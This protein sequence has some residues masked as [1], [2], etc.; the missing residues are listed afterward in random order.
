MDLKVIY[1][2]NPPVNALSSKLRLYLL[3]EIKEAENNDKVYGIVLRGRNSLF[4]GGADIKEFNDGSYSNYP[5]LIDLVHLLAR[6]PKPTIAWTEGATLG[7]GVELAIGCQFR[8]AMETSK[9]A[10]PEINL[11]IIPAAGA[12]QLL[13]RL[14]GLDCAMTSCTSGKFYSASEA[15]AAGAI[16]AIVTSYEDAMKVCHN[17]CSSGRKKTCLLDLPVKG[18][19]NK[20]E[21]FSKQM[22]RVKQKW[23]GAE[24]PL[25]CLDVIKSSASCSFQQGLDLERE[26]FLQ[27]CVS[28]QSK[29]LRYIFFAERSLKKWKTFDGIS[30]S[31]GSPQKIRKVAVIGLGTMGSTITICFLRLNLPV[32]IM[33]A[34]EKK[35]EEGF[36][37]ILHLIDEM[38]SARVISDSQKDSMTSQL[39]K[40]SRF[41]QLKVKFMKSINCD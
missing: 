7:G 19:E 40:S 23:R 11:G 34:D 16:D 4:S 18:A 31:F 8:V 26:S 14:I 32:Y 20:E 25:V 9:F 10:L 39:I 1:L 13:P 41:D 24:A 21:I 2:D 28:D 30:A 6:C 37:R 27:L 5:T 15:L 38:K 22:K 29:A 36:E 12:T 35:L 33:E 3:N 17:I